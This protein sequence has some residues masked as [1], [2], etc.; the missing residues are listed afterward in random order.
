MSTTVILVHGAYHASWCWQFLVAELSQR[1]VS[2]LTIDMP[3][4]D[5][6]HLASGSLAEGAARLRSAIAQVDGPVLVCGHSFGGMVVTEGVPAEADVTEVVYLAALVP[7]AGQS[8]GEAAPGMQDAAIAAAL[9]PAADGALGFDPSYA[10]EIFYH[11]CTQEQSDWATAQLCSEPVDLFTTPVGQAAWQHHQSCYVV[12]D[13]DAA[14]P[15]PVQERGAAR[16][17]ATLR[18]PTSHSPMLSRPDLL[19][20]LLIGRIG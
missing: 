16:C 2:A 12:C 19:A 11:D 18:I 3:G 4:R 10:R 17:D 7:A 15:I 9:V 5:G 1:G 14:V 13:E 6:V 8:A 20:D